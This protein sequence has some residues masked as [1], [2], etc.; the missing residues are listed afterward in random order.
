MVLP[1]PLRKL[2]LTT[3][4]VVSVGWLGAVAVVLALAVTGLTT[5]DAFT[6]R[7]AYLG[8]QTAT[9]AVIVPLAFASLVTGAVSSLGSS[10]GLL[11][12]YWVLIKLVLTVLATAVLLIHA[13][14]I[15][16]LAEVAGQ[17][18]IGAD[19][20]SLQVQLVVD[21]GAALLVLIVTTVLAVYK[22]R[23]VTRYGQRRTGVGD[24]TTL[25]GSRSD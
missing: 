6:A 8:A 9:Y 3:H 1:A 20:H 19:L 5:D 10:W 2:A 22:P 15:S 16:H 11:R 14:P 18:T 24:R 17:R 25:T 7:A 13:Q 23:G 21:A 4:V 12:H